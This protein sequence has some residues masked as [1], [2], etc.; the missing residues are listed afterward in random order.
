MVTATPGTAISWAAVLA[1]AGCGD[2]LSDEPLQLRPADTLVVVAHFD[3]DIIF[4][5]PALHAALESGSLTTVYVSSGDAIHGRLRAAH[6]FNAARIAYASVTGSS[7][8]NCGH[9]SLNGAP[10]HVCQLRGQGISM[11]GLDTADGGLEGNLP[12]SPL[13]LIEG[14]IPDLPILGG[15]GGSAT[16]DTI[17]ESL[18][19]IIA[20]TQPRQIHALDLAATHGRDHSG[21]LLSSSFAFWAAA[22]AR[23]DGPIRWHRGYNVEPEPVTLDGADYQTVV[24]MLGHFDAC[25]V[26]CAPCG[27]PCSRP[28]E[29]HDVWLQRQ[30]SSTRAPLDA[31]G[32]L[33]LD[34]SGACAALTAAGDVTLGECSAAATVHLD[35]RGHLAI[36]DSCLASS[37]G[38]DGPV[39]L[40]PCRDT[41]E[42]YWL[43]DSDGLV[44]NGRPPAAA[45]DMAY[46]HVRCLDAGATPDAPLTAPIC[47]AHLGPHWRLVAR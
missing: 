34:G 32:T 28:D 8:W 4:M 9:L 7:D 27:T 13:H 12:D 30:Y 3:D 17:I 21:H 2:N 41:P 25:Y 29:M 19:A 45:P 14:V 23:Y 37:P 22:R 33:A 24:P 15:P 10:I 39:V 38:N 43:V 11:I 47:G 44:W 46:D 6:T 16:P 20:A 1:L 40:A 36:G 26:G 5:Q 31:Q 35:P 42:Q 18:E